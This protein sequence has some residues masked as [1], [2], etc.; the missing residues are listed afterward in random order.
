MRKR[1]YHNKH[2]FISTYFLAIL[3]YIASL[4][5]IITWIE[6]ENIETIL[7]MKEANLYL[8]EEIIV[9]ND[10]KCMLS[11]DELEESVYESYGITY[12]CYIDETLI[13]VETDKEQMIISYD[14]YSKKVL[15]YESIRNVDG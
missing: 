14:S 8:K 12:S 13:Y 5:T 6:R 7:N 10:I 15:D 11:K 4:I 2:G 3:L 1:Y 9:L